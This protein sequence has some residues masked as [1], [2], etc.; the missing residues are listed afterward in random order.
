MLI[1]LSCRNLAWEMFFCVL[2]PESVF[3]E[4]M[5]WYTR[6]LFTTP[7]HTDYPKSNNVQDR[8][9]PGG[10]RPPFVADT[11]KST[12]FAYKYLSMK[13]NFSLLGLHY[14][15]AKYSDCYCWRQRAVVAVS[16]PIV[17]VSTVHLV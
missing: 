5:S 14:T 12:T 11:R 10:Y 13:R 6:S 1:L 17:H 4:S 7:S 15:V 8:E 16:E 3:W 9:Q 2:Y